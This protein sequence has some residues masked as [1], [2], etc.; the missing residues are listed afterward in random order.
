MAE[1]QALTCTER[2]EKIFSQKDLH[3]NVQSHFIHNSPPI[4]NS[5]SSSQ[6]ENGQ[7]MVNSFIGILLLSKK[8][9]III[10]QNKR[11]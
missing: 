4:G 3:N 1:F 2:N 8:V 6:Y 5:P 11:R 9:Q 7:T 10:T